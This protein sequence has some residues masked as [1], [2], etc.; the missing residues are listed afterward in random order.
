L[1]SDPMEVF[2]ADIESMFEYNNVRGSSYNY[3]FNAVCDFIDRTGMLSVIR[4]HEAQDAGYRMHRRNEK[5]GFPSLITLFSAPNYLDAYNNKGAIMRYENN[6]I[7][8]RQFNS[9]T[10]P[11]NLPGFMN[12]FNWSLPFVAD[13]VGE[14]LLY[15][16]HLVDD[17]QAE[18]QERVLERE[19]ESKQRKR[20]ALRNK[21]RTVSRM[22][23]LYKTMREEH[24][25]NL[26]TTVTNLP[27]TVT[28]LPTTV[29]NDGSATESSTE[30]LTTFDKVK[31][32]DSPFNARPPGI[33]AVL[34][35][36]KME[37]YSPDGMRRRLSRDKILTMKKQ[38]E[39]RSKFSLKNIEAKDLVAPEII[40]PEDLDDQK[41]LEKDGGLSEIPYGIKTE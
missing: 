38:Q 13:K 2:S 10:H 35:A 20:E 40:K 9:S 19:Y 21:V 12:V 34:E 4:A 36:A 3:S 5:T 15:I 23:R 32:L 14:V 29:T 24:N 7:N 26:P 31:N 17:V 30:K 37:P 41:L 28:N 22:L 27:T 25:L 33:Q 6:I 39:L 11:Y 1:W 8:I 18:E 16:M